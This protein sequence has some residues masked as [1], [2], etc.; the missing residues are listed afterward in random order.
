MNGG[1]Y[2]QQRNIPERPWFKD[3]N[4]VLLYTALKATAYVTDGKYKGQII[5]RGS[6]PTTRSDL[7][8]ITGLKRMT[9]DR[10]LKKLIGYGEILVKSSNQFSIVTVCDYDSYGMQESLFNETDGITNGNTDGITNG[11]PTP[12]YIKEERIIEDNLISNF[13][14][15]KSERENSDVAL[16]VKKR[17]NK[18]FSG[19]L[20]PCIRLSTATRIAVE[21]CL[22]RFGFQSVDVV[23]AQIK[24]E[25]FSLGNNKTG[26]I[27]NFTFIFTPKNYQQYIE[28]AQLAR[29]KKEQ[30]PQQ[31]TGAFI[32][33]E[34]AITP[35]QKRRDYLMSW[36]EAEKNKNTSRGQEL[37]QRCYESGELAS[38]GIDWKPNNY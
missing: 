35:Q 26:F 11:N 12:I 34:P 18:E 28:R 13:I 23:F 37:L 27:A 22:R 30:K 25:Q 29:Q 7:M 6:C 5:R 3:A 4:V 33:D 21:E 9:L 31:T 10:C 24:T 17:Y 15:Y 19:M 16:E 32:D 8:E 14:P 1:W 20:P 2:K 36:V 38:L